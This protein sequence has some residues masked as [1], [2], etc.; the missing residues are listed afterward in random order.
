MH[1]TKKQI[2]SYIKSGFM[3]FFEENGEI[4]GAVAICPLPGK[5]DT[6]KHTKVE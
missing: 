2:E 4:L 3:Y 6:K 5:I 1:P